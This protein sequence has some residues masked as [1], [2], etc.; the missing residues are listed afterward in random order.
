M[1]F[2][3]GVNGLLQFEDMLGALKHGLYKRAAD[4]ALN[5]LWAE[6]TPNRAREV[7]TMIETGDQEKQ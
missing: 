6:Q 3:L 2:Q 4:A 7:A 1:A 5:S